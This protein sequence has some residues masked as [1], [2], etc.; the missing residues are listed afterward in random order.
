[1][2]GLLRVSLGLSLAVREVKARLPDLL[3]QHSGLQVDLLLADH[4]QYLV[5]EGIDLALRFGSLTESQRQFAIFTP[6]RVFWLL[7]AAI[8]AEGGATTSIRVDRCVR[9]G[10]NEGAIA[11]AELN[12]VFADGRTTKRAARAFTDFLVEALRS[13]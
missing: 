4:R 8:C 12:A 9:I 11:A 2:R 5:S 1:L 3:R 10:G 6:G 7:P 13:I